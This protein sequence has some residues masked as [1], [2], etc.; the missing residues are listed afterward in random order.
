MLRDTEGVTSQG[1]DHSGARSFPWWLA[2]TGS[3]TVEA[4]AEGSPR[5]NGHRNPGRGRAEARRR[6]RRSALPRQSALPGRAKEGGAGVR[7]ARTCAPRRTPGAPTTPIR[8]SFARTSTTSASASPVPREKNGDRARSRRAAHRSLARQGRLRPRLRRASRWPRARSRHLRP[9]RHIARARCAS[10]SRSAARRSTRRSAPS[11]PTRGASTRI[12]ARSPFDPFTDVFNHK[13]E[14][15]LEFQARLRQAPR[16]GAA[17]GAHHPHPVR[18]RREPAHGSVPRGRPTK[19]G[20]LCGPCATSWSSDAD[21]TV[22]IAG[23]DWRTSARV[24]AIPPLTTR[25]SARSSSAPIALR[26]TLRE[27][28]A[29][30]S[31]SAHVQSDLD[32]RRVC[33]LGPIYALLRVL[34]DGA[35]RHA[36]PLRAD[37][38]PPRRIDRQPRRDGLL[39]LINRALIARAQKRAAALCRLRGRGAALRGRRP[40]ATCRACARR[41]RS[42][43]WP[44]RARRRAVR[45]RA[46]DRRPQGA[47]GRRWAGGSEDAGSRP[48]RACRSNGWPLS[49]RISSISLMPPGHAA[50]AM[51]SMSSTEMREF[52][53]PSLRASDQTMPGMSSRRADS[54]GIVSRRP[55]K[56]AANAGRDETVAE[57]A[58]ERNLE[59]R[60]GDRVGNARE[61]LS[62]FDLHGSREL[63]G[64]RED[65]GGTPAARALRR[66]PRRANRCRRS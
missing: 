3:L 49:R 46:P 17:Q 18:H 59:R 26:S 8:R 11:R 14:H 16:R 10:R 63:L 21:R 36:R 51:R 35:Q 12:A 34:P 48:R 4:I 40:G 60:D 1:G 55:L 9:A 43:R 22:V 29:H 39:R 47:T 57:R 53:M 15:S 54:G 38:R 50:R 61:D 56:I 19:R 52:E 20:V 65:P 7:R 25:G 28:G 44:W 31:S 45:A 13:R 32:T 24:S 33:G 6:A 58:V 2:S 41:T 66:G 42:S 30:A 27:T 23:A 37:D 5:G 62:D 64:V